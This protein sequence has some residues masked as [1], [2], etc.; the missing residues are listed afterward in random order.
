[1]LVLLA[2]RQGET[3]PEGEPEIGWGPVLVLPKYRT[4]WKAAMVSGYTWLV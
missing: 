3:R 1:M 2:S 4:F